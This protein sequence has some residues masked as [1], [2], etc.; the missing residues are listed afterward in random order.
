MSDAYSDESP[1]RCACRHLNATQMAA[2][3]R[4][5]KPNEMNQPVLSVFADGWAGVGEMSRTYAAVAFGMSDEMS[6]IYEPPLPIVKFCHVYDI[7]RWSVAL[8]VLLCTFDV[9]ASVTLMM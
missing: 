3:I 8:I 2:T 9:S 5:L 6:T 1:P 7:Q 4:M